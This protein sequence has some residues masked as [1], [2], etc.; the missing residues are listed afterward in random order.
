VALGSAC[1]DLQIGPLF[2]V[3]LTV[4]ASA[5]AGT[6]PA[7]RLVMHQTRTPSFVVVAASVVVYSLLVACGGEAPADS[8]VRDES[9]TN[10]ASNNDDKAADKACVEP[11]A[12]ANDKGIGAYCDEG[13]RCKTGFLCTGDFGAPEGARFCTTVCQNDGE[14]GA[15]A[16]CYAGDSR[17]KGC[18]LDACQDR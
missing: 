18:V 1:S 10:A 7:E 8:T 13:T 3:F 14:C 2:Q 15:G 16:H 5:N 9:P 12:K 4:S 11:G 6:A 17:G